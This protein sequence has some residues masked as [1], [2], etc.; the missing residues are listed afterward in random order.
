MRRQKDRIESALDEYREF[1]HEYFRDWIEKARRSNP[2]H[3]EDI[4][5]ENDENEKRAVDGI[6]SLSDDLPIL[7][8]LYR[9][10]FDDIRDGASV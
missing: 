8:G 4:R 7:E 1:R 10:L 5:F 2:L 9:D 3:L 6:V